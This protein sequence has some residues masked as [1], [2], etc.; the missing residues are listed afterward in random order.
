[1]DILSDILNSLRVTGSV[2]FC[3]HIEPPWKKTFANKETAAFHLIRRGACWLTLGERVEHLQ[4]GDL[5]FLGPGIDHHLSS[6]H[7]FEA[8]IASKQP[9][10]L[11]CGDCSFDDDTLTPLKSALTDV[12]IVREEELVEHPWLKSTF[13]QIS[14][15]Y[16][17]Q[18]PGAQ[19]IVNKLTEVILVELIR[20]NFA[21]QESAAFVNALKDKRI[22]K[23]LQLMH[24]GPQEHWTIESLAN[25]VGMS[26]ASFSKRF[27]QLVG[28]TVFNYLSMLRVQKAKE[29][30]KTTPLMIDDI[31]T[32]VG[33]DSERAFN[34]TFSKYVG[35]TPK[36]YRKA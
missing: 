1:M 22:R 28:E 11:L 27:N 29:L 30:I 35:M 19:I 9:T 36:Q 17:A 23:A 16:M 26:R 7:P 2:Y 12:T 3:S 31:A 32:S 18:H 33:Y 20:I 25:M 34:K 8:T 4:A 10:L 21:R 5:V 6:E 13:D 15:E 14:A 24:D